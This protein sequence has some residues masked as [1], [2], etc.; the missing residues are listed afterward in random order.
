VKFAEGAAVIAVVALAVG[1][2]SRFL[3]YGRAAPWV[4]QAN[5]AGAHAAQEREA[6]LRAQT[7]N[8]RLRA[9]AADAGEQL[10]VWGPL[11]IA[12]GAAIRFGRD[13]PSEAIIHETRVARGWIFRTSDGHL[14]RSDDVPG[15][16]HP[17]TLPHDRCVASWVQP[18]HGRA[19]VG[20]AGALYAS[21][22]RDFRRI[23]GEIPVRVAAFGSPSWG[24]G[25]AHGGRVYETR[26]GGERWSPVSSIAERA[27]MLEG[28]DGGVRYFTDE[29]HVLRIDG[30]SSPV[31]A[32]ASTG[33]AARIAD[34]FRGSGEITTTAATPCRMEP[35]WEPPRSPLRL[36]VAATAGL[37]REARLFPRLDRGLG[38]QATAQAVV[39]ARTPAVRRGTRTGFRWRVGGAGPF[40]TYLLSDE[41]CSIRAAFDCVGILAATRDGLL[42][43]D[44]EFPDWGAYWR[45]VRNGRSSVP[46]GAGPDLLAFDTQ[47]FSRRDHAMAS[48]ADG[49]FL[50]WGEVRPHPSVADGAVPRRLTGRRLWHCA[51]GGCYRAEWFADPAND[52]AFGAIRQGSRWGIASIARVF[53]EDGRRPHIR[54]EA[55]PGF[56]GAAAVLEG[57]I[58]S[59]LDAAFS[60]APCGSAIAPWELHRIGRAQ[61]QDSGLIH[62]R[63]GRLADHGPLAIEHA[64]FE[65][66]PAGICLRRV[67]AVDLAT[68]QATVWLEARDG[69]LVGGRDDGFTITELRGTI[70]PPAR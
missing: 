11:R 28:F 70:A 20:A 30:R 29:W 66:G 25:L 44:I 40:E 1:G 69:E 27:D 34:A 33:D 57:V 67:E 58:G 16:L 62:F 17:L 10:F 47:S 41:L 9:V 65:L 63:D 60:A 32:P 59:R 15:E 8:Y 23:D 48:L 5:A 6:L 37:P 56:E 46:T 43:C 18:S 13:M 12:W 54:F 26:D 3:A 49:G 68:S 2:L 51:P 38:A 4:E 35:A 64:V 52:S 31:S 22:G 21:D 39:V 19:V 61:Q 55:T 45:G 7:R 42:T 24:L 53:N 36:E 50:A 14:Y